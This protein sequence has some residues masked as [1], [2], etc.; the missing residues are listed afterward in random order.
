V[1]GPTRGIARIYVDGALAATVDLGAPA[2]T[3]R[4]VVWAQTWAKSATRKLKVVVVGTPGR[5]RIDI[6]AFA[7]LN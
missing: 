5:A 7:R 2:T 4:S 3:Y 1:K 6:D